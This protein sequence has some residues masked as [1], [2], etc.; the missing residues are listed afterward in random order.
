V[1]DRRKRALAMVIGVVLV[2]A[3]STCAAPHPRSPEER[4]AVAGELLASIKV[5]GIV[6][7]SRFAAT[8]AIADSIEEGIRRVRV[9]IVDKL[10][11]ELRIEARHGVA[12]GEAPRFCLVGPFSAP[13]D[14]GLSDRCWG[15]PDLGAL[16][17]A[18]LPVDAAG[19]PTFPGGQ[20][21]IV[22][23]Q[24]ER[25]DV[26][27]DYPPGEW[28][29]EIKADP[30][31]DGSS[32]GARYLPH[33]RLDIPFASAGPLPVYDRGRYCGLAGAASRDEGEPPTESP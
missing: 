12:F 7:A 15:T 1:T 31:V 28:V 3:V 8:Y 10:D 26:R 33:V 2:A 14:A 16:V 13:D 5:S 17:A 29:L 4:E 23:A 25:G 9:R 21:V 27:C 24:L 30:V 19:H 22:P 32:V 18:R 11:L 20:P 6:V